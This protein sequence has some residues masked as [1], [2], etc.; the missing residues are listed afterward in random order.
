[1]QQRVNG[2]LSLAQEAGP[3]LDAEIVVAVVESREVRR[4]GE[5][6]LEAHLGITHQVAVQDAVVGYRHSGQAHRT[7]LVES[8][9]DKFHVRRVVDLEIE[10]GMPTSGLKDEL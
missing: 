3:L 2:I 8:F 6:Q 1:M 4:S 5:S 7:G 9:E 10:A